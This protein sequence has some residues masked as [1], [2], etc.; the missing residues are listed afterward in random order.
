MRHI[1]H[2]TIFKLIVFHLCH[3]FLSDKNFDSLLQ[4]RLPGVKTTDFV[5]FIKVHG[6]LA[7]HYDLSPDALRLLQH[8]R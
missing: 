4:G 5:P 3:F 2:S 1:F 8:D 7:F 6:E